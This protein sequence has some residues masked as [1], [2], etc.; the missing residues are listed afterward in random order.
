MFVI[1]AVKVNETL[2]QFCHC[3]V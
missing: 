1:V 3:M 2:E